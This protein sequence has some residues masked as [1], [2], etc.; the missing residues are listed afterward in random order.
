MSS[1]EFKEELIAE[2]EKVETPAEE[3]VKEEPVK[4]PKKDAKKPKAEEPE[5]ASNPS[6]NKEEEMVEFCLSVPEGGPEFE[7][8]SVN[9]RTF[10]IKTNEYI[11][12][13]RCVVEILKNSHRQ[14]VE[15][16]NKRNQAKDVEIASM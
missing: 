10:Q 15:A 13:P 12:M 2:E 3:P 8:V 5:R 1:K 16:R 11:K 9:E 7:F 6:E 4:E 14:V